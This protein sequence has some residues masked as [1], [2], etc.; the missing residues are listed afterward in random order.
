M[1]NHMDTLLSLSKKNSYGRYDQATDIEI[2]KGRVMSDKAYVLVHLQVNDFDKYFEEY[3]GPILPQLENY[4]AKVLAATAEPVEKEG[5]LPGNWHV[6]LE[7]P[8]MDSAQRWYDSDEYAP[9][10][11]LR[12][13]ELIAPGGILALAP[14]FKM[15]G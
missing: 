14:E 7:F 11:E 2:R 3:V 15:P 5:A 10:K 9:L 13:N 12:I 6:V 4:G 8:D 1:N